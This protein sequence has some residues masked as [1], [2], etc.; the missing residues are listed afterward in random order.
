[1]G[2]Q[3]KELVKNGKRIGLLALLGLCVPAFAI[4]ATPRLAVEEVQMRVSFADL[5][6]DRQA[7]VERL[8]QRIRAAAAGACGSLTLR[9]VGSLKA[10][11]ANQDCYRDLIEGAVLKVDNAALTKLHFG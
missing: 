4:A 2:Y 3:M 6:L 11:R 8:Y 9:E 1:R 10:L 7:G 5:D